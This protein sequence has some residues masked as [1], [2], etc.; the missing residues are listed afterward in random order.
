MFT[1]YTVIH[2]KLPCCD[3]RG[4][5]VDKELALHKTDLGLVLIL[6][7]PEGTTFLLRSSF[8]VQSKEYH[9]SIIGCGPKPNKSKDNYVVGHYKKKEVIYVIFTES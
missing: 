9:L 7:I 6:S 8:Q 3:H 4:S 5:T 2:L 1:L